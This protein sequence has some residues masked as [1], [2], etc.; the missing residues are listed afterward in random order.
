MTFYL[1]FPIVS[2][3]KVKLSSLQILSFILS[4][5]NVPNCFE[6]GN[7]LFLNVTDLKWIFSL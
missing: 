7:T 1:L 2:F 4:T 6:Y 3:D 5:M